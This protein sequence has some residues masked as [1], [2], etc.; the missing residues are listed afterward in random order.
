M[1][2][3]RSR[4]EWLVAGFFAV[5]C[6]SG[7]LLLGVYVLGG[8]TQIEGILLAI[9]LG[10]LGIGVVLWAQDLMAGTIVVEM[11]HSPASPAA[12]EDLKA[13]LDDEARF[14]R[15][16][17]L[18]GMFVAALGAL[19]AALAIPILSLGPAPG[20][21]LFSTSWRAG[22][23]VVGLDGKPV[24]ADELPIDHIVTVFP[25]GDVGSA[26]SQTLLIHV[27]PDSLHLDPTQ[28]AWA[29]DGFIAFSKICTHAGCPVGLYR[30]TE[31]KLICPCHQSTF[32]VPAGAIPV[33]GPAA[34][35]LPQLPIRLQPDG[36]FV[37]AGD[38]PEPV[39]PGFWN[40]TS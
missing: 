30:A 23:R 9:A 14:T 24:R 12:A 22:K 3:P 10:S 36:T 39:G 17:L 6:V 25:E 16:T 40:I 37:A 1:N 8:Q 21:E 35:P 31:R 2:Q 38:F 32:D 18:V 26:D 11:R 13:A 28:A 27:P 20:P 4:V 29:P 7:I 5:T 19:G 34:R 15:R 33:F